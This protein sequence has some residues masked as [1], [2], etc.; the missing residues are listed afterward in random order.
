MTKRIAQDP[1]RKTTN[2]YVETGVA[3][4]VKKEKEKIYQIICTQMHYNVINKQVFYCLLAKKES[5]PFIV[6]SYFE[7]CQVLKTLVQ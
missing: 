6:S 3:V 7:L 4:L 5:I 1:I 2:A